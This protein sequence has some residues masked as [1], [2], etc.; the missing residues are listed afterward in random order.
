MGIMDILKSAAGTHGAGKG[1]GAPASRIPSIDTATQKGYIET[2]K[3]LKSIQGSMRDIARSGSHEGLKKL[4]Q[5]ARKLQPVQRAIQDVLKAEVAYIEALQSES[6]TIDDQ[7]K[8]YNELSAAKQKQIRLSN[9]AQGAFGRLKNVSDDLRANKWPLLWAAGLRDLTKVVSAANRGF[10]A[11]ARSGQALD[12]SFGSLAATTGRFTLNMKIASLQASLFGHSAK[13][14]E[15][16]FALLTEA[17]GGTSEAVEEVSSQFGDMAKI[18]KFS[19]LGMAEAAAFAEKNWKRLGKTMEESNEDLARMSLSTANLNK[20]FGDGKVN[21]AEFARTVQD[22]AFQSGNYNQNT[23]FLTESLNHELAVQLSLGKT[24][25]A[26]MHDA[27]QNLI[28]AGKINIAGALDFGTKLQAEFD[29]GSKNVED[30]IDRF[31]AEGRVLFKMLEQGVTSGGT[32]LGFQK[33]IEGSSEMQ[34]NI[35]D[36]IRADA[37]RAGGGTLAAVYGQGMDQQQLIN[38]QEAVRE[39]QFDAIRGAKGKVATDKALEELFPDADLTSARIQDFAK[40]LQKDPAADAR[41]AFR[42]ATAVVPGTKAESL[43]DKL[44]GMIGGAK[45]FVGITSAFTTLLGAIGE[46]PGSLAGIL[47]LMHGPAMLRGAKGLGGRIGGMFSRGGGKVPGLSQFAGAGARAPRMRMGGKMGLMGAGAIA[48][49]IVNA[50]SA[51][52]DAYQEAGRILG[53][54]DEAVTSLDRA[55]VGAA[56]AING[57]LFGLPEMIFGEDTIKTIAESIYKP[58]DWLYAGIQ[59]VKSLLG[60]G[61]DMEGGTLTDKESYEAALKRKGSAAQGMSQEEYTLYVKQRQMLRERK[62]KLDPT[63]TDAA[64]AVQ[65]SGAAAEEAT[66]LPTSGGDSPPKTKAPAAAGGASA[67]A[68]ASTSGGRLILEVENFESVLAQIQ[69]DQTVYAPT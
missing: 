29:A 40:T 11:M 23:R 54:N 46:L 12:Q 45:W 18:A 16:A 60:I 30:Y 22:L 26:A 28:A 3:Q 62:A 38:A 34:G 57:I 39:E 19:G 59:K 20:L 31:G 55:A 41:K 9:E 44:I 35:Q 21:T 49:G 36:M 17:L 64:T 25:E 66:A 58:A 6:A 10:D 48:A 56:A 65:A 13:D 5:Q 52:A 53:K 27:K 42:K 51:Y 4:S 1:A 47:A 63:Q 33:L 2:A 61:P 69:N 8:L 24:R 7:V 43:T 32:L 14:S 67:R 15:A 50:A 68:T 37:A